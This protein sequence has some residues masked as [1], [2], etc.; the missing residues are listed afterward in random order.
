MAYTAINLADI[1]AGKPVKEEIFQAIRANQE[2]FNVDITSIQQTAVIDIFNV[3]FGGKISTYIASEIQERIP[4]YKSPVD[5]TIISFIVTLLT[6]STSGNLQLQLEKSINNG[7]S[8]TTLLSSPVT[9]SASTVG[10][11]SGAVSWTSPSAQDF[12]Q[13]NLLRLVIVGVQLNQ[14]EFQVAIHGEL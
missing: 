7:V 10:S 12:N 11:L 9:V 2:S 1:E 14:G 5:G 3:K 4:V 8:W 13:G 6:A